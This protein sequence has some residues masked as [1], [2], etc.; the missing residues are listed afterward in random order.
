MIYVNS[1]N[2]TVPETWTEFSQLTSSFTID[3]D[4]IFIINGRTLDEYFGRSQIKLSV[5]QPLILTQTLNKYDIIA[6]VQGGG[7]SGQA[8]AIRHGISRALLGVENECYRG[9]LKSAGFL[10]RDARKKERKKCGLK[11]ARKAPLFSKR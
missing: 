4:G 5:C 2:F 9:I 6:K 11:G 10:T 7:F 8:G 3:C 1:S